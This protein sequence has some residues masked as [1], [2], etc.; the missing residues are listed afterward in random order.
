MQVKTN[1][2]D[3]LIQFYLDL[4]ELKEDWTEIIED[5]MD[6]DNIM[7]TYKF[8]EK[9]IEVNDKREL[10]FD[11]HVL[12]YLQ[13]RTEYAAKQLLEKIWDEIL[14]ILD[15]YNGNRKLFNK[16]DHKGLANSIAHV[17]FI[18]MHDDILK[19]LDKIEP[20]ELDKIW[21][22]PIVDIQQRWKLENS[23]KRYT[24]GLEMAKYMITLE[25]DNVKKLIDFIDRTRHS[26]FFFQ[27]FTITINNYA[28][29]IGKYIGK[30]PARKQKSESNG[31]STKETTPPFK[32]KGQLLDDLYAL[33]N[34]IVF[35]S[36]EKN[37]FEFI[38][39]CGQPDENKDNRTNDVI[40]LNRFYYLIRMMRFIIPQKQYEVW[41]E[42]IIK[43]QNISKRIFERKWSSISQ[44][45]P[46][47][48]NTDFMKMIDSIV[49]RYQYS[50]E[51]EYGHKEELDE[52]SAEY[53]VITTEL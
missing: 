34:R 51:M 35:R 26:I 11:D 14:I 4:K 30:D 33:C 25:I 38:I 20:E 10:E 12:L 18:F 46:T 29:A 19:E 22:N 3:M 9:Y 1:N 7:R 27:E 42:R 36:C 52:D 13:D 17:P 16:Y 28:S 41:K 8:Y 39:N 40:H 15:M 44:D 21:E 53:E 23:L 5:G 31:V 2:K 37:Y 43:S 47:K 32:I 49:E 48:E 24:E 45:N 6:I 50:M